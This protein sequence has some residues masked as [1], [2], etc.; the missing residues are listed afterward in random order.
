MKSSTLLLITALLF[1]LCA[2]VISYL[3]EGQLDPNQRKD[4]FA[5]GFVTLLDNTPDFT[6][7]N[8][9][10]DTAFRYTIRSGGKTISEEAFTI[11]TGETRM[12]H[13]DNTVLPK[14]YTLSVFPENNP[15]KSESL[16][17]K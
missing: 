16:T 11:G 13:P 4:W 2:V 8:H 12:M 5:V 15:K 17:R 6:I 3:V 7:T 14:P 10:P 9:S 1:I